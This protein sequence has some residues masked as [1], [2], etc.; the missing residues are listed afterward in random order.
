M[1][2]LRQSGGEPASGY[3]N[4]GEGSYQPDL[5]KKPNQ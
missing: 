3:F 1:D 5:F 2:T 4:I